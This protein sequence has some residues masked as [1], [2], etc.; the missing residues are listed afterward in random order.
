MDENGKHDLIPML[1]EYKGRII[2]TFFGLVLGIIFLAT[3][4]FWVTLVFA[5]IVAAGYLIG[6][7][8]DHPRNTMM[9]MLRR[10]FPPKE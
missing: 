3:K 1:L 2:G 4:D 6:K 5:A 7:S 9:E 8:M 10:Y